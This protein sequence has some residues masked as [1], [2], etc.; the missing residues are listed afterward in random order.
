VPSGEA[1]GGPEPSSD[2]GVGEEGD[3]DTAPQS[4]LGESIGDADP[5]GT[6]Y[7]DRARVASVWHP[8]RRDRAERWQH[9]HGGGEG[10]GIW[11][12]RVSRLPQRCEATRSDECSCDTQQVAQ[13]TPKPAW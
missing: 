5:G 6:G 10:T 2:G 8:L 9:Q 7:G 3:R 11:Q 12:R 13:Y 4:L 1:Q